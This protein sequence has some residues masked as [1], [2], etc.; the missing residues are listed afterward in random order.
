[1]E[2]I[3]WAIM[4]KEESMKGQNSEKW[5]SEKLIV[6]QVH[7]WSFAGPSRDVELTLL[8]DSVFMNDKT[9]QIKISAIE[10][11][12]KYRKLTSKVV[13]NENR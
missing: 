2:L 4:S 10:W 1:M 7:N 12:T 11:G 5:E 3:A 8:Y 13:L 9:F 6:S